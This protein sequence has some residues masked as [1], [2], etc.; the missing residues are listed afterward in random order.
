MA[1]LYKVR[2]EVGA[3]DPHYYNIVWMHH[4]TAE[5][6]TVLVRMINLFGDLGQISFHKAT[7]M[8]DERDSAR[9]DHNWT[10]DTREDGSEIRRNDREV[11]IYPNG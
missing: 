10:A 5:E 3:D 9:P 11:H 7:M 2:F 1:Q 8:G 4:L 6:A